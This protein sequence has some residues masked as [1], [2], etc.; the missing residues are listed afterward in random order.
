MVLVRDHGDKL[1][2]IDAFKI[3]EVMIEDLNTTNPLHILSGLLDNF[4]R[5]LTVGTETSKFFSATTIRIGDEGVNLLKGEF[6]KTKSWK[7]SAFIKIDEIEGENYAKVSMAY[8]LNT[9][10][11]INWLKEEG[12]V[13]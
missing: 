10:D 8:S 6:D 11:Y 12:E 9:D 7:I 1:S 4:G 13:R 2:L 3:P 5:D